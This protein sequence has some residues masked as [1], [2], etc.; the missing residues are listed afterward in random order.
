MTVSSTTNKSGPYLGNGSTVDFDYEFRILDPSHVAVVLKSAGGVETVLPSSDYSISGVGAAVGGSVTLDSAPTTGQTVTIIRNAPFTQSVD[1]ENQGAYYAETIEKALDL[2]VMRDQ[3]LAERLDRAV[4]I[5]ISA[6][7]SELDALIGNIVRLSASADEIDTVAGIAGKVSTVADIAVDV[8]EVSAVAPA[9]G[10]VAGIAADVTA[11]AAVAADV[12]TAANNIAAII[13]APD[14]ADAAETAQAAAEAAAASTNLPTIQ[15]GDAGKVLAVKQDETGY[16]LSRTW[17]NVLSFG[18]IGDGLA[19][20]TLA[21][22]A[23]VDAAAT[24]GGGMVYFPAGTYLVSEGPVAGLA[25]VVAANNTHLVGDGVGATIIRLA[26]SQNKS[27]VDFRGSAVSLLRN[28]S[29]RG[30][31]VDGNRANQTAGHGVRLSW[32]ADFT[33]EDF[34]IHD[35]CHYGIGAQA[36]EISNVK[37]CRGLIENTG[38]DGIDFKNIEDINRANFVSDVTVRNFGLDTAGSPTQAGIDCRGPIHLSNIAVDAAPADGTGVRF[39]QGELLDP[40]GF[41][42]HRSSLSGFDIRM[43]AAATGL[44][45]NVLARDVAISD[46][47]V[48]GGL[49]GVAIAEGR[50]RVSQVTSEGA[51]GEGFHISESAPYEGDGSIITACIARNG[52]LRGFR[53]AADGVQFIGCQ[54][55]GN[56]GQGFLIDAAADGTRIIGG[57]SSGNAAAVHNNGSNTVIRSHEGFKTSASLISASLA[58]DSTGSKTAVIP[59]GLAIAPTLQ[60]V[61]LTFIRETVVADHGIAFLQVDGVDATNISVRARVSTASLTGGA[62]FKIGVKVDALAG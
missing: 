16:L 19:D 4:V 56:G 7:I 15:P 23:A 55:I 61:A 33:I 48:S 36:G 41:G 24:A 9:V 54:A 27:V 11:V 40:N 52:T 53:T 18:A 13:A 22:Q 31:E 25:V 26:D 30:V 50:C 2:G 44:G 32:L 45:I 35:A 37:I 5:P 12:T 59:H 14:A 20:D 21:I 6:D 10:A 34:Y 62:T 17:L 29:L 46:G 60:D 43:G 42:A 28:C 38:G 51:A 1:L 3:Q 57:R 8:S 47:Y 58:L 39:R 49:R